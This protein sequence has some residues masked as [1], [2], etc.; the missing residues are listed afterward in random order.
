MT[1]PHRRWKIRS[2][3]KR[4]TLT[5]RGSYKL[6]AKLQQV[7]KCSRNRP[8]DYKGTSRARVATI[9]LARRENAPQPRTVRWETVLQENVRNDTCISGTK[10]PP[11]LITCREK[12]SCKVLIARK[13]QAAMQ[14]KLEDKK[15]REKR[16]KSFRSRLFRQVTATFFRKFE[17]TKKKI[18]DQNY[19]RVQSSRLSRKRRIF[20]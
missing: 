8:K 5:N 20:V 3:R 18:K 13:Y 9:F 15:I 1:T 7:E 2:Q 4:K 10:W 17:K 14:Q 16:R 11:L 19:I 6:L 12:H